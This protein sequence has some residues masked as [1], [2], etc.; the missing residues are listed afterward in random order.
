[1]LVAEEEKHIFFLCA[2]GESREEENA[3]ESTGGWEQLLLWGAG[4][5]DMKVAMY[6]YCGS[7]H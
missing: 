1:M 6:A 3:R 4:V 5:A 2:G 7:A